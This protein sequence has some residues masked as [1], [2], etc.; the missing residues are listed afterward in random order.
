METKK[1]K[2]QIELKKKKRIR[3]L[4]RWGYCPIVVRNIQTYTY[5]Q[6]LYQGCGVLPLDSTVFFVDED[7]FN[8]PK[9]YTTADKR[10]LRSNSYRDIYI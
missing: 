6:N 2:R 3:R 9:E 10:Q 1:K 8:Y 4:M 7:P 5:I